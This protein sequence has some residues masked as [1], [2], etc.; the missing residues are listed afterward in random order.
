[1][2]WR[3]HALAGVNTLWLLAPLAPFALAPAPTPGLLAVL[4]GTAAFGALLPD[5]DAS[6]SK[7]KSLT[8]GGGGWR[9]RPF[10]LPAHVLHR[11][12]GHRG[13]LHSL[14]GLGV[15][16]LL[17]ALPLGLW[18]GA[19]PALALVLGYGSHLLLD[20]CTKSGVPLLYPDRTRRHAL[21]PRLRITTGSP[22]EEV[23][24]ALLGV[25]ALTLLLFSLSSGPT[26]AVNGPR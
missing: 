14:L 21:A 26:M 10:A 7:I 16:A 4:A 2:M 24:L 23:V 22:A 18:L 6:E 12:L 11:T 19:L 3:T 1:M 20:A 8:L 15:A 25:G 9:L 5:L 13:P 17:V